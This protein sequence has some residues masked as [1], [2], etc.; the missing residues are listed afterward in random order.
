V[1][2]KT[3]ST[4]ASEGLQKDADWLQVATGGL[5]Q[6]FFKFAPFLAGSQETGGQGSS[7]SNLQVGTRHP[8]PTLH[9]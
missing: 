6:V 8:K 9:S 5:Y 7:V 1:H 2:C 4:K 3:H